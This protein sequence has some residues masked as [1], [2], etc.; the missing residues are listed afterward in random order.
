MRK[1]KFSRVV[2]LLSL[3]SLLTDVSSEMLYPVMP[4]YLQTIGFSAVWIGFL[5]GFAQ[6]MIGFSTGYFGKLSDQTGARMPFVRIG[7][8]VSERLGRGIRTS[9]R[10]ALLADESKEGE[11]GRVFGFHR[12]MDT[13]GAA[14]GPLI[15]LAYLTIHPGDYRFLFIIAFVPGILGAVATFFIKENK[16][17]KQVSE[18]KGFFSYFSYWKQA[19]LQFKLIVGGLLAFALMNSADSF[20]FMISHAKG[21]SDR[22]LILAYVFYNLVYALLAYPSG[23]LADR[24]GM[25]N[26]VVLGLFFFVLAYLGFSQLTTAKMLFALFGLYGLFAAMTEGITK[27]WIS[28]HC[29]PKDRGTAMGFYKSTSSLVSL[30]SSVIA[31]YL[32]MKVSPSFSILYSAIGTAFVIVYFL[33]FVPDKT[34]RSPTVS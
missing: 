15:A 6:V 19:S 13:F 28:N 29:D 25:R 33:V 23:M 11:R 10:D 30:A 32:W 14:I 4:L 22:D 24:F 8:R 34:Q 17:P 31:G 9:A 18:K 21:I 7:Y 26:T 1:L 20:L 3:V 16:R 2:I 5:E 12:A 27:A